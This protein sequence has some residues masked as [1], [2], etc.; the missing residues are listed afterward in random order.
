MDH[1]HTTVQPVV[2]KEVLPEQHKHVMAGVQ[3]RHIDHGDDAAVR[4]RL[5]EE[6]AK[7]HDTRVEA[8]TVHTQAQGA[9]IAGEHVHHHGMSLGQ[10]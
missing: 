8:P 5:E 10:F 2:A 1:Y 7:F 9:T 4:R 6:R 3:E